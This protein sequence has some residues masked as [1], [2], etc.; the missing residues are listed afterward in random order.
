MGV[1][2]PL[3]VCTNVFLITSSR[4]MEVARLSPP[5]R[6]LVLEHRPCSKIGAIS[7]TGDT[8]P[9]TSPSRSRSS[10]PGTQEL[11]AKALTPFKLTLS[12]KMT[13][14]LDQLQLQENLTKKE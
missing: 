9:I 5:C 2:S 11:G 12:T 7:K 10:T 3:E 14:R 13:D 8:S 1:F 4:V 6:V